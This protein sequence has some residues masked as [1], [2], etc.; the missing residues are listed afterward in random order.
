MKKNI[1]A[2]LP[3][4]FYH[5]YNRG[6]NGE[7]IFK[8]EDN[9]NYFLEKYAKY[10]EPVATTFAYVLMGNHFHFLI[11]TK[12]ESDIRAFYD[13]RKISETQF[14]NAL[15]A[16]SVSNAVCVK[17]VGKSIESIISE[18]FSHLFNS[19]AQSINKQEQRTGGLFERPFRRIPINNESYLALLVYYIHFNPEKHQFIADFRD[20]PN[21]SYHSFISTMPTKLPRKEVFDWFGGFDNFMEYHKS[22]Y[23][24]DVIWEEKSWMED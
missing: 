22:N 21:S 24:Y 4:T 18:Q 15:N 6:I 2:L 1:E 3:D 10:V 9:Y 16:D 23:S 14:S 8:K 5:I 7:Q 13:N 12:S 20:Y 17:S 11:K 19:F